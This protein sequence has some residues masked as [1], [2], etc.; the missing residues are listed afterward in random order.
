MQTESHFATLLSNSLC[1]AV[2]NGYAQ[3]VKAIIDAK[4]DVNQCDPSRCSAGHYAAARGHV[5]CFEMLIHA[6]LNV[7]ELDS[8][9]RCAMQL[10]LDSLSIA[11]LKLCLTSTKPSLVSSSLKLSCMFGQFM[12]LRAFQVSGVNLAGLDQ[13]TECMPDTETTKQ[14]VE[15]TPKVC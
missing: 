3:C 13:F 6:G 1:V 8:S 2:Q 12:I 4:A 5:K 10:S 7:N 14:R 9:G 15:E 11:C